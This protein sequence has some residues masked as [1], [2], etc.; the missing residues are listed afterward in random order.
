MNQC[1]LLKSVLH[2][3]KVVDVLIENNR[4]KKIAETIESP[5]G[6]TVISCKDK[7]ILPPFYNAHTHAAM[8]LFRG[9]ADDMPLMRWL[10]EYIWPLEGKLDAEAIEAGTRLAILEM[11]KSGTVFF[12]DMYWFREASIKPVEEMGVRAAIG[13]TFAEVLANDATPNF[14]FLRDHY[15][16]YSDRVQLAVM[17]HAIYTVGEKLLRECADIAEELDLKLHIHLAETEGE[18]TRSL[19]PTQGKSPVRYLESLGVLSPRVIAAHAIHVSAE[20]IVLLR[21]KKVTVVHNPAS[22]MKLSS[23]IFPMPDMLR[24]GVKIALGTDGAASNNNLDM[25]ESMKFATLLAKVAY[26]DPELLPAASV[27]DMATVNGAEA[28]GIDA[29]VI[30]EG[31]LADAILLDLNNERFVP[32]YNL[33]SNWVYSADSR[34]IDT[35]ICNGKIL[36][37]NGY[38]EGEEEIIARA[39]EICTRLLR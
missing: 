33:I 23:G 20:D 31:K 10:S 37:Q 8:T 36:M 12:S 21:E 9:Y 7:A 15:Q 30:A 2:Q 11:I 13:V 6:A 5:S 27:F 26:K 19:T 14:K 25:R 4:F 35:V 28:Y 16:D 1:I 34:A 32:N 38:V 18:E 24:A 39:R 22:N 29:G 17:P 3:G